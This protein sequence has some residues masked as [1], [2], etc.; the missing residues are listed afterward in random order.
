MRL[1]LALALVSACSD[2][3]APARPTAVPLAVAEAPATA[4]ADGPS[5]AAPPG[6]RLVE[7]KTLPPTGAPPG[8]PPPATPPASPPQPQ[9]PPPPVSPVVTHIQPT[10]VEPPPAVGV[11]TRQSSS[12]VLMT[13]SG[14]LTVVVDLRAT[15][16]PPAVDGHRLPLNVA[17]VID[18]SGSM[19][20][21]KMDRTREAA[22]RFVEGLDERDTFALVSYSDDVRVD[23]AAARVTPE[24]KR[25]ALLEIARMQPSGSTNLSGG[26]YRGQEQV[27]RNL[28]SGQVNRVLLMSDGLANRGVI[29]TKAIA[30][31]AQREAQRGISVTTIGVGT[32]YNEDL[33]TA[34]A[35]QGSGNY[36]FVADAPSVPTV[37]AAEL[38][39]MASTVAQDAKVQ[40]TLDDGS[41][42]TSVFGYAYTRIGD[43]V[44]VPLAEMF[45]GQRRSL[46]L[47]LTVPVIREGTFRVG[48]V[49]VT[50]VD[51]RLDGVS[52]SRVVPLTVTVTRDSAQVE[53]G[54]DPSVEERL[55]E[56][57]AAQ[58]LNEAAERA[59]RGDNAGALEF[60][61]SNAREIRAQAASSGSARMEAQFD[62][63]TRA[64]G[65]L[66]GAALPSAAPAE[67]AAA[68]KQ[69]KADS[70][71]LAR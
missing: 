70:F 33:M 60:L 50:Y 5:V 27:G 24:L 39:K 55:V 56:I 26:L 64:K 68:V 31:T 22:K 21:D 44:V 47:Q 2:Y 11:D 62:N 49:S 57:R 13:G 42:L 48:E 69:L 53:A 63:L 9:T 14:T 58:V 19:R 45:G 28:L 54:R 43:K 17:L 46:A 29:D 6:E 66:E 23:V 65:V 30:T 59:R 8:A 16:A 25:Q 71:E 32:D 36:Y 41:E 10:V 38:T 7:V 15:D 1:V 37:L 61:E 12:H 52:V 20:G 4:S 51:P 18:R 40:L 3:A 35:D 67:P 34:V